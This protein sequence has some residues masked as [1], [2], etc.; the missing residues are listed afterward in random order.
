MNQKGTLLDAFI[1]DNRD[2]WSE[3]EPF[4]LGAHMINDHFWHNNNEEI[5]L[6]QKSRHPKKIHNAVWYRKIELYSTKDINAGDG[7]MTKYDG[8]VINEGDSVA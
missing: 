4:Y 2:D 8:A 6:I 3:G 7:I 5:E 1:D